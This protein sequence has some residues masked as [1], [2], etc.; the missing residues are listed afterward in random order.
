MGW[1]MLDLSRP[2]IHRYATVASVCTALC[3]WKLHESQGRFWNTPWTLW[4]VTGQEEWSPAME[5]WPSTS[6]EALSQQFMAGRHW[7]WLIG[8]LFL[9]NSV[10]QQQRANRAWQ[11]IFK[12]MHAQPPFLSCQGLKGVWYSTL[13]PPITHFHAWWPKSQV[14]N[15]IWNEMHKTHKGPQPLS[16]LIKRQGMHA[17]CYAT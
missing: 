12:A 6:C 3:L 5:K 11:C 10:W 2:E 13:G 16:W 8:H 17:Q 15:S 1:C 14:C 9:Q 7:R 4:E